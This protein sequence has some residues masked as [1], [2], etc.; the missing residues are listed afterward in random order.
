LR[1]VFLAVALEGI[2]IVFDVHTRRQKVLVHEADN[3]LIRPHLGIQ[4]STASSH[5]GGAEIQEDGFVL[6]LPFLED[7]IYVVT[8]LDFHWFL[9]GIICPGRSARDVPAL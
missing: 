9:A 6:L 5:R 4:P 8:E 7:G 2:R 3:A 1:V